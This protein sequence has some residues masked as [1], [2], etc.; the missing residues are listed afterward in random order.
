LLHFHS[1]PVVDKRSET[2]RAVVLTFEVPEARRP[3]FRFLAGQHIALK[4]RV[5][6]EELRRTYSISSAPGDPRLR[7]CVRL[8]PGGRFSRFVAE[9]LQIGATV[10]VL[11]PNGSFHAPPYAGQPRQCIAFAAGIGITPVISIVRDLLENE[12]DSRVTLFYGNR[13]AESVL[14]AEELLALK[15]RFVTRLGLH[16]LLTAESQEIDLYN[17]R[18][19]PSKLEAFVPRLFDARAVD[20]FFVSGP[21]TMIEDLSA[22]LAAQGVDP[23]RI[24]SEHFLVSEARAAASAQA[25][26]AVA[27]A[28]T[29]ATRV[30]VTIDGRTRS[31]EMPR[32]GTSVLDAAT[33]AGLDLPFSCRAGVCSTCRTRV[34]KGAVEMHCNY[35]LEQRELDEGY[36]LACQAHPLTGELELT[37]DSR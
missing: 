31:F 28:N 7:I 9:E 17:G 10:D 29:E 23:A 1:L 22:A 13:D 20:H 3:D 5:G 14:F 37:Y 12:A 16:F 19:T 35:A 25:P 18:L 8:V 32:D 21:G 27:K 24:H 30:S 2:G 11:T 15:D 33:E 4:A 34:V 36:I 26:E 6:G